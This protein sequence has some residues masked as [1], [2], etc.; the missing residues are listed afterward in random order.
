M[1]FLL[2]RLRCAFMSQSATSSACMKQHHK[3]QGRHLFSSA[4]IAV[5]GGGRMGKIRCACLARTAGTSLSAVVEPE[6][7]LRN[8]LKVQYGIPVFETL[9][10]LLV[11]SVQA[12]GIWIW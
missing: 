12:D 2:S 7:G 1:A 9:E 8:A 10:E 5:V 4:S 3:Q 11:S 6:P